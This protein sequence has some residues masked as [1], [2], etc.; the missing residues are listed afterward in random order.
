MGGLQGR[1]FDGYR[2]TEQIGGGGIA[3]VYRA[4]PTTAGGREAV[5]KV[6][7]PEFARQ[8]G[9]IP[10]FRHIVQ[11]T[12]KLTSHPHILPLLAHGEDS[13]YLYFITPYVKDGTLRDWLARGGRLNAGDVA[14][15]FRQLGDALGYVHSMGVVHGN[16]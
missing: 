7:H 6:V 11:M 12:G 5:V 2:R 10:N 1:V 3:E 15:I 9:F 14:P 8:P 13:G 16:L 4:Q